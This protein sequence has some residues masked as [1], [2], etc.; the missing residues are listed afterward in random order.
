MMHL[1]TKLLIVLGILILLVL[2]IRVYWASYTPVQTRYQVQSSKLPR[3]F[4]GLRIAQVSDL[5]NT[6]FRP[7][8]ET[9]LAM[10]ADSKPDLIAVTGDLIDSKR[11]NVAVSVNFM[12]EAIKIAPVYYVPGNHESRI[13]E[14]YAELK[15]ALSELGVVILE[16]GNIS[17]HKGE[18]TIT[19]TGLL[20]PGFCIPWPELPTEDYRIVLSHRPDLF[21]QYVAREFDLVLTGHAHG[22]QFRFPLIGGLF[23]PQQGLFPK[24][25]SGVH[26]KGS[27]TM[28]ISRGLG[29]APIIPRFN[30][31][32]EL[33]LVTLESI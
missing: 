5:H 27:T 19:V 21:D 28:V 6:K 10:L 11:T 32:P 2:L 33:I 29:N 14:A 12:R 23:A 20:D 15:A 22:G 26:V 13:P 4:H 31:S 24:Y 9:L 7:L 25:T 3:T 16:N 8:N 18:D 17:L 1:L 30:N